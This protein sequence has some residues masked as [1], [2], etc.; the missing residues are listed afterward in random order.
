MMITPPFIV[1]D[2]DIEFIV[3]TARA[4]LDDVQPNL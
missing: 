3:R 2:T 1:G 4:A